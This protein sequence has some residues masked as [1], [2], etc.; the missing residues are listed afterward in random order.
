M[1][2][3]SPACVWDL[4]CELG[5]GPVWSPSEQA[6][7]FVDIKRRQ[8]HRH[9]ARTG[10]GRSWSAPAP[11][12]FLARLADGGWLAGLKTGL[13]RFDPGA[14]TF[15]LHCEVEPDRPGNRL[16]DGAVDALGR[17]WFGSMDDEEAEPT[18]CLYRL[19]SG[20]RPAAHDTGYV[21]TNGPAF[22]PDL[23][24][25]YHT[26]TLGRLIYAF[27]LDGAGRLGPRRAFARI[28][29]DQGYPDGPAVDAEGCVWTGLYG[30][31]GLNRYAPTG[32]LLR[33][34]PFP[35]ANVT[36]P[37]FGGKDFRTL[38]ATTARKGLTPEEIEAQPLAGG[39]FALHV[40]TPGLPAT[41]A[42][43]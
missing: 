34:V 32:E 18:G 38:Y 11:P 40:P 29:E 20:A 5:E 13:H 4:G 6:L 33:H 37:A 7:W 36:K 41:E 23:K 30:G 31:W 12:G 9:D 16:N 35:C 10:E 24:T 42:R 19:E 27:D 3:S 26:D 28:A 1:T 15:A 17:L 21:I 39:L 14:G 8:I 22:S 2:I 43:L 25:L